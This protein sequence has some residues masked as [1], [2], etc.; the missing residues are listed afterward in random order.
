MVGPSTSTTSTEFNGSD[1][2][3]TPSPISSQSTYT[4]HPRTYTF[5]VL[6]TVLTGFLLYHPT[7]CLDWFL[8]FSH[9]RYRV[10]Y[11]HIICPLVL[12]SLLLS[13]LRS[14]VVTQ[15]FPLSM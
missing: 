4:A 6:P 9:C 3:A 10:I 7:H 14:T 1:P 13:L 15:L 12:L 2:F 8:I 5:T 11:F